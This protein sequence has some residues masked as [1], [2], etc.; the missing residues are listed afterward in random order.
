MVVQQI[1]ATPER[2]VMLGEKN[3]LSG[4]P[5]TE[6]IEVVSE[7]AMILSLDKLS[8]ELMLGPTLQVWRES[9]DVTHDSSF[10]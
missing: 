5:H 2:P 7:K 10:I 3:L 8:F 6:T 4:E 1:T 9:L